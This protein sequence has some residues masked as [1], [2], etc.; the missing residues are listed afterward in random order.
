MLKTLQQAWYS[1]KKWVW[2]LA[3]LS[4]LFWVLSSLRRL[5]YSLGFRSSCDSNIPVVV[6]G[7]IGIGGN[8]KTPLVLALVHD[9]LEKGYSPAVL[10]RG[11]GGQ[12]TEFPYIVNINDPAQLVGDEPALIV[13][14]NNTL[15]VIDPVRARGVRFIEDN[16]NADVIICDDGLQHYSMK[17]DIELCVV[18]KRG[19]GNGYLLPMGPLREGV[20][21]LSTVDAVI[22]NIGF[23]AS[24]DNVD[25]APKIAVK[26]YEMSLHAMRW[27]NV[28][29]N[30]SKT[31]AAFKLELEQKNK[32]GFQ[33]SALAGIGDPKRFFDTLTK[34]AINTDN[35]TAFADHYQFVEHDLPAKDVLL[36]TEKDAVKCTTFAHKNCWYLEINAL[37][38]DEFFELIVKGIETKAKHLVQSRA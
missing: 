26:N 24:T 20:W 4:A 25:V 17:R 23:E 7:N 29:S 28:K 10:S 33:V 14:R 19:V 15:L 36:M 12:Q 34:M 38:P 13:K 30:E 35:Q 3:P 5:L 2:C 27:V 6:V 16:T 8:G 11:Y 1:E 21:R 37:L 9:L 18:D 31:I 32:E 22:N